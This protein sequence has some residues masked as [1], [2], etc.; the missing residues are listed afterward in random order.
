MPLSWI[1]RKM[2][3]GLSETRAATT[4][5]R[6]RNNRVSDVGQQSPGARHSGT[7]PLGPP[8]T[9]NDVSFAGVQSSNKSTY[10]RA[11]YVIYG[12]RTFFES[13]QYA[14]NRDSH[15]IRKIWKERGSS[16]PNAQFPV[17]LPHQG[18]L[19]W[20]CRTISWPGEQSHSYWLGDCESGLISAFDTSQFRS[21]LCP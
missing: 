6:V 2:C 18:Q 7:K 5:R 17:P 20:T 3:Y 21:S 11:S 4:Y 12:N 1:V 8:G 16:T 15:Q 9:R 19:R 10:T 13:S 14:L